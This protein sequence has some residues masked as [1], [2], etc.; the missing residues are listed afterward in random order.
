MGIFVKGQLR[1]VVY[2]AKTVVA[3][4]IRDANDPLPSLLTNC[5]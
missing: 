5:Y 1:I 3:A 2:V 4:G